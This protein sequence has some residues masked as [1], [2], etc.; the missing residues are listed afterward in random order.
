MVVGSKKSSTTIF[1][2]SQPVK[3]TAAQFGNVTLPKITGTNKVGLKLTT[4]L[5]PWLTGT[6]FSYTWLRNGNPIAGVNTSSYQ[7]VADDLSTVIG[8]TVCGSKQYYQDLCVT[9]TSTGTV[10][11]GVI[12]PVGKPAI[13]GN[14][15]IGSTLQ[16]SPG[17]WQTGVSFSYQWLLDGK[18]VIGDVASSHKV[19]KTDKGHS[20]SVQVTG[21]IAGFQSIT[22]VSSAK[23]IP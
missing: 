16:A 1:R 19:L 14:T 6:T 17:K 18:P 22:K 21:T 3:I 4:T 10:S 20:L 5:K 8:L 2:F 9:T 15:T 12:T 13:A 23:R 11:L 7:L